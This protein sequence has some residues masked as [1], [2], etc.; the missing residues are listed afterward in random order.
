MPRRLAIVLAIVV[1]AFLPASAQNLVSPKLLFP[2]LTL[3]AKTINF[4]A[5]LGQESNASSD[6]RVHQRHWTKGGKIMTFIGVGL[7]AGGA[8]AL[9]YGLSHDNTPVCNG[10][11]TCVAVD[12]KW[13]GAGWLA[14]GSVLTV[15]GVTRHSSD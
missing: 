7:M 8:A 15:I 9:G 1:F 3:R 5:A 13:T 6:Q 2:P 10:G 11:G 12:W 14:G 4:N